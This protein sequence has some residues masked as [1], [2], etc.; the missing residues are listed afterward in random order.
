MQFKSILLNVIVFIN[1]IAIGCTPA[2]PP[3]DQEEQLIEF[4]KQLDNEASARIDSAYAAI[5]RRCDS[6][7]RYRVPLLV[8]SLLKL[9]KDTTRL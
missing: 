2:V 7:Q 4:Q 8:D 1:L 6:I 5:T 9:P 3:A